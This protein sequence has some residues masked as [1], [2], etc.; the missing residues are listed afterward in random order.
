LR[1]P[2]ARAAAK[3]RQRVYGRR[4][5]AQASSVANA[6]T[7][8]VL[9]ILDSPMQGE[10]QAIALATDLC[11]RLERPVLLRLAQLL[12]QSHVSLESKKL[13]SA[14]DPQS[15]RDPK[16]EDAQQRSLELKS[17]SPLMY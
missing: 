8:R 10:E 16:M 6:S 1:G 15:I 11:A 2:L 13:H 17:S 7:A 3:R 5:Y 12:S 14:I 4:N 9:S